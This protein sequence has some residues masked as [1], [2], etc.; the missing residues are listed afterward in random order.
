MAFSKDHRLRLVK[1]LDKFPQNPSLDLI[2]HIGPYLNHN[3]WVCTGFIVG[4]ETRNCHRI[5]PGSELEKILLDIKS[6]ESSVKIDEIILLFNANEIVNGHNYIDI[7]RYEILANFNR[8]YRES[9]P[10]R[11]EKYKSLS[12]YGIF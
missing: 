11:L 6:N 12:D 10:K 7:S 9:I 1:T 2:G 8:E 4:F 3:W 5:K